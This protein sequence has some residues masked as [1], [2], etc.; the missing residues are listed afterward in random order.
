[1]SKMKAAVRC[2]SLDMAGLAAQEAHGK[3]LDGL[4]QK[5]RIRDM[6][7]I[8][9]GLRDSGLNLRELYDKHVDGANMN[10]ALR[11]TVLHFIVRFPPELLEGEGAGQFVGSKI[12]RQ[13][14]MCAQAKA[15]INQTHGG[16]AV[17]AVR[18]DRDETG[19]SIVD[20]F[21][22]PKYE[23]RTKRTKPDET[24]DIWM[25]P[26]KFGKELAE[27]HAEEIHRRH[28]NAKGKLTGPR[29]VGIALQSEFA[30][31][32]KEMNGFELAPKVEKKTTRND[33]IEKE[34]HD[35]LEKKRKEIEAEFSLKEQELSDRK[36][37]LAASERDF[38]KRQTTL[39]TSEIEMKKR[40]DDLKTRED[41][42]IQTSK[43]IDFE[44][45]VLE[46]ERRGFQKIK[47]RVMSVVRNFGEILGLPLPKSLSDAVTELENEIEA[48]KSEMSDP[49]SDSEG[50]GF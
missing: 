25:S 15:F 13:K 27:K 3:R 46:D 12:D 47:D 35:E 33:R 28:P 7:P 26:T 49:I 11:K 30:D 36:R 39:F 32:F 5:R 19:E 6:P 29:H 16:N 23:K 44:R 31:Y 1:M 48:Q 50:P 43:Q 14:Q 41:A 22:S 21:A 38:E 9:L 10:S 40:E 8:T 34:A 4:S 45:Q 24:G 17:F 37:K 20:V 18:L 2:K 42:L